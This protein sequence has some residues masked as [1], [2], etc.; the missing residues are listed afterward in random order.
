MKTMQ[1]MLDSKSTSFDILQSFTSYMMV[2][3]G[4]HKRSNSTQRD[5]MRVGQLRLAH[6]NKA[7][8]Q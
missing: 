7:R 5:Q 1:I 8:T 6:E 2:T 4:K 3:A